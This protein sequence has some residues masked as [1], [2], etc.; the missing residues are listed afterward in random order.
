MDD[1]SEFLLLLALVPPEEWAK[2]LEEL[3]AL[4]DGFLLEFDE[5]DDCG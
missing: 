1:E 4:H 3:I 2:V 5:P